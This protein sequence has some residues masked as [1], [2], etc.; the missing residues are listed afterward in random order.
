MLIIHGST[1]S[2][3]EYQAAKLLGQLAC[4]YDPEIA[5]SNLVVLE[6]F[7]SVQCFGQKIQDIDL[8][9]F[10]ADYRAPEKTFITDSG[11]RLHSFCATIEVKGHSPE[12]VCF[13]GT[14][15]FVTYNGERHNVTSQSENQKYSVVNYIKKHLNSQKAPRIINLIWFSRVNS[16]SLPK[17]DSNILGM[18]I[19]WRN[20][21]EAA[22]LIAR[23]DTG[24]VVVTFTSRNWMDKVKLIFSKKLEP[25]KI[26]RKRLEAITKNV[27]DRTKQQYAEMLGQQL[28]IFR[29]RR[30]TG[31]TVRLIQ[32]A[33]QAYDEL[34]L[35]VLLLTYNMALVA[36]L[37]RLFVLLGV[38]DAIGESGIAIKTIHSFMHTWLFALGVIKINQSDFFQK[39]EEYKNEALNL[40]RGNAL[41][42]IDILKAKAD[43]SRDL[44][45]DLILIDESQD[46]P[47]SERD[48]IYQLYGHRKVVITDGVDQFVRGAHVLIGARG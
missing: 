40:L 39:Y 38:K 45:W 42:P 47:A 41:T 27:L 44:T 35:R 21:L 9:V 8:L 16:A 19:S 23:S 20:F 14:N 48:L 28:L 12:N 33:Y 3:S 15:C 43:A 10:Y 17:S 11:K 36:D 26:D 46:W 2:S 1:E 30:G 4:D 29:G 31:K 18:D 7:P 34:G 22:V 32:I 13:E 24:K 6:I 5:D 25:S 37:R